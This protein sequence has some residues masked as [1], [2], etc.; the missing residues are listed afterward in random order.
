MHPLLRLSPRPLL[1]SGIV[2]LSLA[3]SPL[4]AAAQEEAPAAEDPVVATVDGNEIRYS[5][6]IRSAQSL[7]AQYQQNLPQVFPALVER[8]I[9]MQLME[10]RGRAE[11]LANDEQVKQRVAHAEA[12]AISQLWLQ[13][14]LEAAFTEEALDSAYERWLEENPAQDEVKARHILVEEE[15]EAREIIAQ[16]EEGED[17]AALAETHS[18]DPS[19][20]GRGGD[21]GYFTHDRM[22]EPFADAAF[23]ME[24]GTYSQ[25][26]VETRFGWHVILVEDRREGTPPGQEAVE[27]QL[28]EMIATDV[29][30]EVRSELRDAAEIEVHD[31]TGGAAPGTDA[32]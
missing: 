13:R 19:A 28:Q 25:E 27:G 11:G 31:F 30:Q 17:F 9:D 1:Y 12:E 8:L 24:P 14:R 16:L 22:V 3:G 4:L 15:E 20:E 5:D 18:T 2:A 26:P 6:V 32:Q 21:L 10:D 7:P 23:A 29:I